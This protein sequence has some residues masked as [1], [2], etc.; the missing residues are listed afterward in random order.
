MKWLMTQ[1]YKK[2]LTNKKNESI[3][4]NNLIIQ[5]KSCDEEWTG[6]K[7][8]RELMGGANQYV[9]YPNP[10]PSEPET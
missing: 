1:F 8:L 6:E 7:H 9:I 2:L 10:L 4:G 5:I 3:I